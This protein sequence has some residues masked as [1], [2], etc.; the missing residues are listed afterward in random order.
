MARRIVITSGKGGVGKT[1]VAAFLGAKLAEAGERVAVLD[2][3]FGLNNLDVAMGVEDKVVYDITDAVEGRCRAKQALVQCDNRNLYVIPSAHT[4]SKQVT[5]Q[6][7]KLLIDGLSDSFDYVL[8]D[9]PAGI[10]AGFQRAVSAADEA[11]VVVTPTLSSLRDADKVLTILKSYRL[12]SVTCVVNRFRADLVKRGKQMSP[13][14]I[15]S[16]LKIPVIASIPE[17]DAVLLAESY[18]LPYFSEPNGRFKQ[19]ARCVKLG[20]YRKYNKFAEEL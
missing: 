3:D 17:S 6:N 5:G 15:E 12:D 1:S 7:V 18:K 16:V 9:S 11:L 4:F 20:K 8:L 13:A 19:L 2:L 10:D 14:E